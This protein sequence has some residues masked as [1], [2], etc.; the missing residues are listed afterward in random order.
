MKHQE[1][2]VRAERRLEAVA[3]R[4]EGEDRTPG[5]DGEDS[6]LIAPV[7][8]PRVVALVVREEAKAVSRAEEV[9]QVGALA[10]NPPLEAQA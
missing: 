6:K 9:P 1:F 2:A 3:D 8:E 4:L 5:T 10:A 7:Q